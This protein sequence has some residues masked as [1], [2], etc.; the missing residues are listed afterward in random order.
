M[1]ERMSPSTAPATS[2]ASS[3]RVP[4]E[5]SPRSAPC[6]AGS[7]GRPPAASLPAGCQCRQTGTGAPT[8][9][10]TRS[11][12]AVMSGPPG[13]SSTDVTGVLLA[14]AAARTATA[15]AGCG[16][17]EISTCLLYTSDAADEED[18]VDL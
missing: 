13:P 2:I 18:S 12:P 9:A 10:S 7:T 16:G 14:A 6:R 8:A 17:L 5:N 1:F 4:P 11:T 15:V 3:A